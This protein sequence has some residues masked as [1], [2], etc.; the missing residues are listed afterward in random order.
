MK[1]TIIATSL[2]LLAG[3]SS[4][5]DGFNL[6]YTKELGGSGKEVTAFIGG[7]SAGV[8]FKAPKKVEAQK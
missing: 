7:G 5:P 8:I 3:C 4:I 2:L 1:T 6:S